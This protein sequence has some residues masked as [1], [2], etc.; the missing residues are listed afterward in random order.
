VP[1]AGRPGGGGGGEW[2]KKEKDSKKVVVSSYIFPYNRKHATSNLMQFQQHK[3]LIQY[4][5]N[6]I[7]ISSVQKLQISQ[8]CPSMVTEYKT[9]KSA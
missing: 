8:I 7:M 6:K 5:S 4:E 1:A 3:Y 2:A 9:W